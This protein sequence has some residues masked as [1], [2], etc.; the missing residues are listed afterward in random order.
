MEPKKRGRKKAFSPEEEPERIHI[1][2]PKQTRIEL[3]VYAVR[4]EL[5]RNEAINHA[6]LWFLKHGEGEGK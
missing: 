4:H 5:N 3:E 1:I 2:L 6:I